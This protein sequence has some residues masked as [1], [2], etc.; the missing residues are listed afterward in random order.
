LLNN[1]EKQCR[2]RRK[3]GGTGIFEPQPSPGTMK[4][5]AW[6]VECIFVWDTKFV[7]ARLIGVLGHS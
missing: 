6:A 1:N 5:N 3:R 4:N 7:F 2:V